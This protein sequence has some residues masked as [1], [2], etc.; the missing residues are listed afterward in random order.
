MERGGKR[1]IVE[2]EG[3]MWRVREEVEGGGGGRRWRGEGRKKSQKA[4]GV[5]IPSCNN[6]T[7]DCILTGRETEREGDREVR[8]EE[9]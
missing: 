7:T 4:G 2:V 8:R 5:I 9:R 3:R 6:S 1:G